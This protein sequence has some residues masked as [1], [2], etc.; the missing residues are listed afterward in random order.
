MWNIV[1]GFLFSFI[2]AFA[3]YKKESLSLSGAISA[4]ILG[5]SLYYFGGVFF[6]AILVA[7][8]IS[9]S[10]LTKYKKGFKKTLEDINEKGGKRDYAQV[11]ANGLLGF[12]FAFIFYITKNHVF[13]L[14]YAT[15]FAAANADTWAS[16]LGVLSR[17]NPISIITFKKIERGMSGGVS[18]LG[19]IASVLGAGFIGVILSMGYV[20]QYGISMS[21]LKL[22]ILCSICGFIGSLV[23]SLI[24][25]TIQ[26]KYVCTVCG[27]YTE[28]KLHH[29]S[30]TTH[31]SGIRFIN[32]DVVN[33][34][35]GF[36]STIIAIAFYLFI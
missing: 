7:F 12:I 14:A 22:F 2:I 15:A 17:A 9:S 19:I 26:A 1:I 29:G 24:G 32:N 13:I 11:I 3:G 28:K 34:T 8:F 35:S 36:I 18:L 23:D 5:T 20:L 21:C 27:K 25:S 16:E 10:M 33:F 4:V 30:N 31:M 6:S